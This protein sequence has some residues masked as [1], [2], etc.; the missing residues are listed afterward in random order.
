MQSYFYVG[1]LDLGKNV[2]E[3]S[4][5]DIHNFSNFLPKFQKDLLKLIVT[6]D[7]NALTEKK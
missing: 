3:F 4:E 2:W 1:H 5:K 6:A 7:F